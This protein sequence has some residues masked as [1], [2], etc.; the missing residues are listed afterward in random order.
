MT[1]NDS[2]NI[3]LQDRD[4][5]CRLQHAGFC[6]YD[7]TNDVITRDMILNNKL[8]HKLLE[9]LYFVNHVKINREN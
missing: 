8:P 1:P 4:E 2:Q 7:D 3:K 9:I 6:E 5:H